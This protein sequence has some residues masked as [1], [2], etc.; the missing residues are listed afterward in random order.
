MFSLFPCRVRFF[1]GAGPPALSG[2]VYRYGLLF[3]PIV[4]ATDQ[5]GRKE[6]PWLVSVP[7]FRQDLLQSLTK[8]SDRVPTGSLLKPADI[9]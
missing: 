2:P 5:R 8:G 6:L 3:V 4:W 1:G 9:F 7:S